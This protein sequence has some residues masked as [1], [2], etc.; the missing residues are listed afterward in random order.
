MRSGTPSSPTPATHRKH[1]KDC[2]STPPPPRYS[3]SSPPPADWLRWYTFQGRLPALMLY[4]RETFF[5]R[6]NRRG[7]DMEMVIDLM[8]SKSGRHLTFSKYLLRARFVFDGYF[9][10]KYK[11][12]YNFLWELQL[13]TRI[14]FS[15]AQSKTSLLRVTWLHLVL[16]ASLMILW[17][18]PTKL[19][20]L[21]TV[22]FVT[23]ST[24]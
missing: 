5:Q 17:F 24:D 12:S 3:R 1:F 4:D 18:S 21:F 23:F 6:L 11:L 10:K 19:P 13:F 8:L 9:W 2:R 22:N 14:S 15:L 16:G 7:I 20:L